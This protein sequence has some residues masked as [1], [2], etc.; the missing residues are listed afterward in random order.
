MRDTFQ[1]LIDAGHSVMDRVSLNN[2]VTVLDSV[3]FMK[4]YNTRE[5]MMQRPDLGSFR[6]AGA[7][8]ASHTPVVNLLIEQVECADAIVINKTDLIDD[9]KTDGVEDL[10]WHFEPNG[11]LNPSVVRESPKF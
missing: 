7:A 4:Q 11:E 8:D 2:M 9:E 3:D 10:D 5:V 6:E 1:D